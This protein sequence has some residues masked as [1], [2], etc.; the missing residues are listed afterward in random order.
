MPT[1]VLNFSMQLLAVSIPIRSC[2][3]REN[4]DRMGRNKEGLTN[5][6]LCRDGPSIAVIGLLPNND[7]WIVSRKRAHANI[8]RHATE[9]IL[10]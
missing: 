10:L 3:V 4:D 8:I 1:V 6:L 5:E 7:V 9:D 2:G